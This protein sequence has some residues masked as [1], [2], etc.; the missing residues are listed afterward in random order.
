MLQPW[1]LIALM[2]ALTD[3]SYQDISV[4]VKT[5]N[6][7]NL[8]AYVASKGTAR[9]VSIANVTLIL[10]ELGVSPGG[11]L[12]PNLHVWSLSDI[13][14]L[15]AL[16]E[17]VGLNRLS[18]FRHYESVDN[19]CYVAGVSG[20]GSR[21]VLRLTGLSQEAKAMVIQSLG[22]LPGFSVD[23]DA[24]LYQLMLSR[25]SDLFDRI[26][27]WLSQRVVDESFPKNEVVKHVHV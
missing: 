11:V 1:D 12:L 18:E 24:E 23:L 15:P 20:F 6:R 10:A 2:K 14:Y 27:Y 21:V 26:F 13:C 9:S 16:T 7:S 17:L 4:R 8:S 5:V 25:S 3:C 19:V 22:S